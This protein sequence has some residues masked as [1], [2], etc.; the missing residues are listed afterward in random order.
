MIF[1]FV[2]APVF[3]GV[4]VV[5]VVVVIIIVV[6]GVVVGP[7]EAF[8]L[9]GNVRIEIRIHQLLRTI[10][11]TGLVQPSGILRKNRQPRPQKWQKS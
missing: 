6:V 11:L 3:A 5:I 4:A 7:Q 1:G 8:L 2:M 9:H 10:C